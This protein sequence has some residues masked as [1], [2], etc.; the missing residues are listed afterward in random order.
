MQAALAFWVRLK[1]SGGDG[2]EL[3]ETHQKNFI[4]RQILPCT[5]KNGV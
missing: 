5:F 1:V 2:D 4:T 3:L